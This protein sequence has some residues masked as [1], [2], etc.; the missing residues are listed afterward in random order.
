MAITFTGVVSSLLMWGNDTT[1]QSIFLIENSI[2]SRVNVIIKRL[3]IQND[4]ALVLTSVMPQI[5]ATRVSIGASPTLGVPLAKAKFDT[6]QNS[7]ANVKFWCDSLHSPLSI[8]EGTLV[9]QQ[10]TNRPHTLIGQMIADDHNALTTIIDNSADDFILTPGQG[11][12]LQAVSTAATSNASNNNNWIV[13][14][15]WKEDSLA[16][17]NISGAVTL[18]AV[19]VIGAKVLVIESDDEL[20]TNAHIL[21]VVTTIAGGIWSSSILSGKVGAAFVQYKD[22]GTY[23]TAPGSPFLES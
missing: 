9:W 10:F 19:P 18:S 23:Y 5:K 21:E 8:G 11:L 12:L 2:K 16:T 7:D 22:G 13:N 20:L 15:V 6:S 1:T 3:S 4:A 14:C 17:F